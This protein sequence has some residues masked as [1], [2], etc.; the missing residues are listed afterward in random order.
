MPAATG[1]FF[2][3]HECMYILL[4]AWTHLSI[5][6]GTVLHR[7]RRLSRSRSC[8][9]LHGSRRRTC[10]HCTSS[11]LGKVA[12]D[13]LSSCSPRWNRIALW[14][15]PIQFDLTRSNRIGLD[16]IR[17]DP[18]HC[19]DWLPPLRSYLHAVSHSFVCVSVD[20]D[21]AQIASGTRDRSRNRCL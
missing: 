10:I 6:T 7:S 21:C 12:H 15:D 8:S 4:C 16:R 2:H 18:N 14:L 20:I 13:S 17:S 1:C 19:L 3:A 9:M 5:A 11:L